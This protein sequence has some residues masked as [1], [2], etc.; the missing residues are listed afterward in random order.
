MSAS[1]AELLPNLALVEAADLGRYKIDG[2][3]PEARTPS[4]SAG[5]GYR[6]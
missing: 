6:R 2:I 1:A 5:S 3:A 4:K